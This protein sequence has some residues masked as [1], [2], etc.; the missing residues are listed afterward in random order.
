MSVMGRTRTT[1]GRAVLAVRAHADGVT[2]LADLRQEAPQRILF[3]RM[4]QGEPF[5]AC[6]ANTSGGIV[7]G[8]RME[9]SVRVEP[10]AKA[11]V[12]AQAAEKVYRSLGPDSRV[13]VDLTVEAGGL[14]E[15]LPQETIVFDAARLRRTTRLNL[16][17][18]AVA[19]AG[20]MLVFG[21]QAHGESL[22]TGLVRDAWEVRVGGRLVWADA[23]H[24]DG[25]LPAVLA[26]PAGLDGAR[27]TATLIVHA[28]HQEALRDIVRDKPA[29]AGVVRGATVVGG[30]LVVRW[31][32]H[33]AL[34]MREDFGG[35]WRALRVAVTA[36]PPR[37]P[38]LWHT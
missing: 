5:T 11:L 2:R 25:D 9:V 29:A 8:D 22:T 13:S 7:G 37:L 3:P 4:P 10:G 26:H 36:L 35:V 34:A 33:D 16:A 17:P 20:E 12:M 24:L 21:R 31:L 15:W 1:V 23:L 14:L 28:P 18:D 19:L 38:R 32:G 30:L 27:A 6:L